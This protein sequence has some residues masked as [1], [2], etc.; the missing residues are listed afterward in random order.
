MKTIPVSL[1]LAGS[2]LTA[3]ALPAPPEASQ[4]GAGDPPMAAE[5]RPG[6]PDGERRF[7]RQGAEFWK[8]ADKDGDGFVSKEEFLALERIAKLPE[9]KRDKLFE[10]FDKDGDGKLSKEE[11]MKFGDGPPNGFP[12]LPELDVDHSGGV[13]FEEFK[14]SEFVKK[15]PPE[16]QEAL[17]KRLDSDGDGQITPKDRPAEPPHRD[18]RDGEG[19]GGGPDGG[20]RQILR[21]LD[22]N[23]DG[24]VT[25]EEFQKAPYAE[26]IGEDALEKRFEKLDRNGDK[27]LNAEDAP[28]RPEKPDGDKADKP[29][30]Q[31][32]PHRPGP[33]GPPPAPAPAKE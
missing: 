12:R 2:M 9:E 10:R 15:L 20:L 6:P 30:M 13:S 31:D 7:K 27:K 24:A 5:K 14:A 16:R 1:V 19:G 25:F 33:P 8:R 29:E 22:A 26:K 4:P 18:G 32:R 23:G 28:P 21:T 11:L 3:W 17:F